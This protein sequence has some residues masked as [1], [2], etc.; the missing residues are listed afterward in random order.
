MYLT[1]VTRI[2]LSAINSV[3]KIDLNN[4]NPHLLIYACYR[5]KANSHTPL[6]RKSWIHIANLPHC[7][8]YTKRILCHNA[9]TRIIV[10]II[11]TL[12]IPRYIR[13]TMHTL[14][15]SETNDNYLDGYPGVVKCVCTQRNYILLV[16]VYVC[17]I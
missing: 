8:T 2:A 11:I 16:R 13:N 14:G 15:A 10:P 1:R 17:V 6:A 3:L 7:W 5:I 4:E 12:H 9:S